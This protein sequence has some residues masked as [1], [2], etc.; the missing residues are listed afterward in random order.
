[1]HTVVRLILVLS[2]VTAGC[3]GGGNEGPT[4]AELVARA[5]EAFERT[6][7]FQ[8][9]YDLEN[10]PAG[11]SGLR[12]THAEGDVAVAN[13]RQEGIELD[14]AGTFSGIPLETQLVIV[15]GDGLLRDPLTGAWRGLD[16]TQVP[17][18]FRDLLEGVPAVLRALREVERAGE[19]RIG[20]VETYRL[21]GKITARRLAGFLG[22]TP[23][24]RLVPAELW[25]GQHDSLIRR[26]RVA[27][28]VEADEPDDVARVVELSAFGKDVQIERPAP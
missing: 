25:V 20:G 15:A 26:I 14:V 5:A 4:A 18:A 1:M 13:G 7:S 9:V 23:S 16:A 11:G 2:L 27:G 12:L 19:D 8:L 22:N 21:S 24:E 6:E 17:G 10:A 3:G 28:P